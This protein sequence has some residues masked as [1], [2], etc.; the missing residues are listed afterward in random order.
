MGAVVLQPFRIESTF[1]PGNSSLH[2]RINKLR[3]CGGAGV[4]P[5]VIGE[6]RGAV[7]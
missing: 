1:D 3:G 4:Q 5:S 6:R 7:F 2:E